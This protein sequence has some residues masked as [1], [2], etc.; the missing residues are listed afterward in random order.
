[1]TTAR[2]EIPVGADQQVLIGQFKDALQKRLS[3]EER[4]PTSTWAIAVSDFIIRG[5]GIPKSG[6]VIQVFY[7]PGLEMPQTEL[8]EHLR[9]LRAVGTREEPGFYDI[10]TE[11]LT[12]FSES[13]ARSVA[14]IPGADAEIISKNGG[15]TLHLKRLEGHEKFDMNSFLTTLVSLPLEEVP[16]FDLS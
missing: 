14:Q 13:V 1:M 8:S 6:S 5:T 7:R 15:S 16:I 10:P 11:A 12:S 2:A 9:Y 3:A 4:P